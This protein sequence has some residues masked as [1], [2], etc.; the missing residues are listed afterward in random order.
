MSL[1]EALKGA[2]ADVRQMRTMGE[3]VQGIQSY[4][5]I[6]GS[7]VV[8]MVSMVPYACKSLYLYHSVPRYEATRHQNMASQVSVIHDKKYGTE[9]TRNVMDVYVPAGCNLE[10]HSHPVVLFVHGGVWA[11]GSKWHYSPLAT[12]LAEEGIVTCVM[13]YSL[14][15]SCETSTMVKEVSQALDTVFDMCPAH[16]GGN[17]V[18]AGHSAGAHLSALAILERGIDGARMPDAFVGMAGV[19]HI[20]RHFEYEKARGVHRLSTMERAVG[21][22]KKFDA[23]SPTV[24]LRRATLAVAGSSSPTCPMAP[25]ER[26]VE[27]HGDSIP[28]RIGFSP[29]PIDTCSSTIHDEDMNEGD[30]LRRMSALEVGRLPPIYLMASTCGDTTVPWTESYEFYTMLHACGLSHARLLLYNQAGHGDYATRWQKKKKGT[31]SE[32]V[33]DL[34]DFAQDFIHI[35]KAPRV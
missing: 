17:V 26:G 9:S 20:H 2:I 30:E 23:N 34:P 11:T 19:Y 4:A 3:K 25:P 28:Q 13:E 33:H 5:R 32:Y 10:H 27:L 31:L 35:I 18:L 15:P 24:L 12:R 7:E 1:V 21:G 16:D 14:F 29:P 6:L 22:R 8:G